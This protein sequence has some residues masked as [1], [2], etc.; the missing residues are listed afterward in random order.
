[1]HKYP[2]DQA[3]AAALEV[4]SLDVI[5]PADMQLMTQDLLAMQVF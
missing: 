1:M 5:I 3:K 2:P 4:V